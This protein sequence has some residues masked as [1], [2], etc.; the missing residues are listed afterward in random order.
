[1]YLIEILLPL[2]DNE[3]QA[4]KSE[5]F[6]EVQ[7]HLT[8]KFGGLTAFTRTPAEGLW[9]QDKGSKTHR[10]DIII[11]EVLAPT[12]K[13]GWWHDYKEKLKTTFQQKEIIIKVMKM[14]LV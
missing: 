14:V 5:Y 9:K 2:A 4:F 3:H 7:Q 12:F 10:D 1:M 6:E 11:F 8:E 13:K